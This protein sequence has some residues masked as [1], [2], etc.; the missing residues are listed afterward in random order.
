MADDSVDMALARDVDGALV[1]A[2]GVFVPPVDAVR[3]MP[4]IAPDP[5]GSVLLM[6]RYT[7]CV[8]NETSRGTIPFRFFVL[9]LGV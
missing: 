4:P 5:G 3:A 9:G 7:V 6:M 1:D 2:A 8:E